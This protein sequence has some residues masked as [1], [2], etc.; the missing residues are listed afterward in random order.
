V[1]NEIGYRNLAFL[2][3]KAYTE[4]FYYRPR[5]DKALLAEHSKGLIALSGC[6][7]G[8]VAYFLTRSM[9]EAAF[10]A[11]GEYA[12]IFGPEG[13]YIELMDHGLAPQK[14]VNPKLVRLARSLGLPLAATNDCHY[15]EKEDAESHDALL[16]IQ[17]NKK[18]SD[19][20]RIKFGSQEFYFKSGEEMAALFAEVPE[21]IENTFQIAARCDY[22]FPKDVHFLP[23]FDPPGSQT[24]QEYFEQVSREGF[25][26]RLGAIRPRLAK[27]ESAHTEV[28][29]KERFERE[30]RLV[31]KMEFEGYFLI[32]WDL[33]RTARQKDIPV[34]PGRGSAAGSLLAFSLGIT[35]ID[36]IEY[37]LLFER[38][39]NPERI[40]LPDIDM[41]F[42]ARRREEMLKYVRERYGEDNVCQII[43]FGTMAARAAIRDVGRVLEVP[44]AE[45]DKIAKM[46]PFAPGQEVT[47]ESALKDVPALRE[48]RDRNSKIAHLLALAQKVE[49]QVRNPSI[50]AA[51]VVITPLPLTEFV[52]LY[53]S[54]KGEVTT[55]FP[56]KDVESI[57]LL[58]MDLLGL[59]NLTII[60]DALDII[61]RDVGERPDVDN[62]PLDDA[63]TFALFQ[64]A[65]TDGVFQFESPGMKNLLR[66]YRPEEFR[67]LIALNALFRPGPLKSGMTDKFVSRKHNPEQIVYDIPSLEPILKETRGLIVYQE[68]VMRIAVVLAG[69]SM[70]QADVLRKAMG[71]KDKV[72]MKE[73]K[74]QFLAGVKA[75][76]IVP[77]APAGKLFDQILEFAEYCF[78]KSHSA[79]YAALAFQ[80]AWLKA[81]YPRHFMAALI[82]S[83]AER[84]GTAQVVKYIGE[85]KAM[86]IEV[87]PP[88]INASDFS[89]TVKGSEIR[90]GLSAVKN[91]GE[92]AA[93]AVVELRRER[94]AF[95]TPF[96]IVRDADTRVVNRKV[97]ESLIKA[98]ALDSLGLPRSQCFHLVDAMIQ[99]NREAQR[100]K[101]SRQSS[102][103]GGDAE[104]PEISAEIRSMREWD[105]SL[106]LSYEKEALGFYITGHPL[107]EFE[108]TLRR[109][110]SHFVA[111][112][113]DE[114]DFGS[115]VVL[116]G[117]IQDFKNLKTKKEE[118]MA[119]F[120]LEDL[121]GRVEVVAFP[122]AFK[123]YYEFIREDL[124]V[125]LKGKF[126]GEGENR[127]IQLTAILPLDDALQKM[128][129]QVILR[130][131]MPG[132]EPS[133]LED[134]K[135]ILEKNAGECP[136]YFELETPL[137]YRVTTQSPDYKGLTPA[138][139]VI[140]ALEALLGEGTVVV[141]Y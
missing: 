77:A 108:T 126:I 115:E 65:A 132:L 51:G 48:L 80:T 70:A 4:G 112:L 22:S 73:Q 133:T 89:F 49:G 1:Q 114:R 124:K 25:E 110:V 97:L 11:A 71:K 141:E 139:A 8:E 53:R 43:T 78:N 94:G 79:A 74:A 88:D 68:Q 130:V 18:V 111:D 42:C 24:V 31:E 19:P 12:E 119:S 40:S 61:E 36:P 5:V 129:K 34:G 100:A 52:P 32:V 69:F 101:A 107:A 92:T 59:R 122:D 76:K 72:L 47:I 27:G 14:E 64:A 13:F 45:V 10:K 60:R 93:R 38:F 102:L 41:D 67:D 37:D 103:F 120:S 106:M 39:L 15:T 109:L 17:T 7:K 6:L 121:T 86:G 137:S 30:L 85:C 20:D 66:R 128:A 118:Q 50:H 123:K 26:A 57:G 127:K 2:L 83:E 55:Q 28:E 125:W 58:K 90:F 105:E 54:V 21:A 63:K 113:D 140:K 75:A 135:E 3:S 23:R 136:L 96:D 116:A 82:S 134:L 98:G 99:F 117:I 33:L 84:G 131:F 62:L 91:V 95:A 9:D 81:H 138:P 104:P 44:L 87:L 56:M 35:D 46:I 29:Y 16:C